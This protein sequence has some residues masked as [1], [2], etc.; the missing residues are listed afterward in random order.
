VPSNGPGRFFAAQFSA[1]CT[2]N[3]SGFDFRQAQP[4]ADCFQG[5]HLAVGPQET[6]SSQEI[7]R[8]PSCSR[9]SRVKRWRA[10]LAAALD[11]RCPNLGRDAGMVRVLTEQRSHGRL[12]RAPERFKTNRPTTDSRE[13]RNYGNDRC[14]TWKPKTAVGGNRGDTPR[15]AMLHPWDSVDWHAVKYFNNLF[16]FQNSQPDRQPDGFQARRPPSRHY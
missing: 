12:T 2:T 7:A 1:G 5:A 14:Q 4:S 6:A 13:A 10:G 3:M 11:R 8:L 16:R 9:L 15:D